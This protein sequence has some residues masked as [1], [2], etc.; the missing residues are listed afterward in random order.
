M[1]RAEIDEA[2]EVF[3]EDRANIIEKKKLTV[4]KD[5]CRSKGFLWL[6]DKP[7]L[8]FEWS[9]ASISAYFGAGGP[10]AITETG[11]PLA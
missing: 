11:K 6:S 3:R 1:S 10:L 2:K 8:Y 5:V 4:F 9:S 7:E